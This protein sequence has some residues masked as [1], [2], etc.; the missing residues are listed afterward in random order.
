MFILTG[1]LGRLVQ[2]AVRAVAGAGRSVLN[3]IAGATSG[4][5]GGVTGAIQGVTGAA[6]GAAQGAVGGATQGGHSL[7][8]RLEGLIGQRSDATT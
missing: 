6:G 8:S 5:I 2:G 4:V 3:G 1:I 7:L